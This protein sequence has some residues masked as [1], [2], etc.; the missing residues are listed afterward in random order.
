MKTL[1]RISDISLVD[2]DGSPVR[3]DELW[4]DQPVVLVWLRHYG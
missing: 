3:L 1:D 4:R 2:S